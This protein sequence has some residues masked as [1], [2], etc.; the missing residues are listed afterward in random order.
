MPTLVVTA[1]TNAGWAARARPEN[2]SATAAAPWTSLFSS[3]LIR[4]LQD[5]GKLG[6]LFSGGPPGLGG[7][8]LE[9]VKQRTQQRPTVTHG[10][11]EHGTAPSA[12]STTSTRSAAGC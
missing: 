4:P 5:G 2:V 1:S 6:G 9:A 12:R 10:P 11:I 7:G 8:F 3:V